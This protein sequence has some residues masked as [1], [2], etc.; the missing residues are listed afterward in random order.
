MLEPAAFLFDTPR[1]ERSEQIDTFRAPAARPIRAPSPGCRHVPRCPRTPRRRHARPRRPAPRRGGVLEPR[2]EG[3]GPR[4]RRTPHRRRRGRP[5][6]P[7]ALPGRPQGGRRRRVR[8]GRAGPAERP[9]QARPGRRPQGR[10]GHP[11]V[12][13]DPAP[14][15]TPPGPRRGKEGDFHGRHAGRSG[16]EAPQAGDGVRGEVRRVLGRRDHAGVLRRAPGQWGV[17]LQLREQALGG[18]RARLPAPRR[19]QRPADSARPETADHTVRWLAHAAG[20]RSFFF[21]SPRW[22]EV[23]G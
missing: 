17:V 2:R 3:T 22:G 4:P 18:R 10:R 5:R 19:P 11:Q 13:H 6:L 15:P 21:P 20:E 1:I 12:P 8:R 23:R 16:G 7:R 14:P 9:A